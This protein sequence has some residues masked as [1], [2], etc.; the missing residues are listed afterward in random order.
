M[1]VFSRCRVS[2]E[3]KTTR[4]QGMM[5]DEDGDQKDLLKRY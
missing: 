2:R 5:F 4:K 1:D 3:R